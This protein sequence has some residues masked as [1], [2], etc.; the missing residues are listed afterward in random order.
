MINKI[1]PLP[2]FLV[3][4][5]KAW[6]SNKYINNAEKFKR[7]A[8][9]GQTPSSLII[10]CCDSRVQ[11][12]SIF[13][14]DDGEFFIHR[15]ISNLVPKYSPN[16]KHLATLAAI[17]YATKVLK[18]RHVIILGHTGCGGIKEAYNIYEKKISSDLVFVNEWVKI[19]LPALENISKN[20]SPEIQVE[21]LGEESIKNSLNNLMSFPNIKQDVENDKLSIHCLIH[22]IET[23]NL[24]YLNPNTKQFENI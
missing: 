11:A 15:N 18:V 17:E 13:G 12:T 1:S 7:L 20:D 10:S 14:S 16:S 6:K 9:K 22:D 5:Y 2:D 4:R 19:I 8:I 24:K 3:D 23:G 21:R